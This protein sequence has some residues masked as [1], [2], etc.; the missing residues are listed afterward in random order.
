MPI[1]R[2]QRHELFALEVTKGKS[3]ARAYEVA[4]FVPHRQNAARLMTNENIRRR[5]VELQ[6]IAAKRAEVTVESLIDEAEEAR[7]LAIANR[8]PNAMVSATTLKAKLTG[9]LVKRLEVGEPNEFK[10]MTEQELR[11][12][13]ARA[14]ADI[15]GEQATTTATHDGSRAK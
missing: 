4:G 3:A 2:N 15:A 7:L 5:V 1:L 9:K 10:N 11:Q 13:I 14:D 6:A 12:F 8:N